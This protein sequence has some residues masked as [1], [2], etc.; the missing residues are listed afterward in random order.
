ML[1][2]RTD[3]AAPKH[4]GISYLLVDMHSPGITVRP[5]VQITGDAGFNEVFYDNVRVPRKT[6]SA[7]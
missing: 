6:W 3:A 2:V 4:K 1:L 7:R 5:L